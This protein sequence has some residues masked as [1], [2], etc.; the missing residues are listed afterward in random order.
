[1]KSKC[2]VFTCH[3]QRNKVCFLYLN[4]G[5][6]WSMDFQIKV[7]ENGRKNI[8]RE[9]QTTNNDAVDTFL[10]IKELTER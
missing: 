5:K 9:F 2:Y 6:V 8:F 1:M 4:T 7:P 10:D 3:K